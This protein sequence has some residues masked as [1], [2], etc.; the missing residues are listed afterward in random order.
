M[1]DVSS[2]TP[3]RIGTSGAGVGNYS[4]F[5]LYAV[6][7]WREALTAGELAAIA[8]DWGAA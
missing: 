7:I 6:Y 2:A 5:E 3:M 1:G 4:D 8:A